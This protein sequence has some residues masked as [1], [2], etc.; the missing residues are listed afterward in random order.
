MNDAITMQILDS[1][2]CLIEILESLDFTKLFACILM[3]KQA[4]LVHVLHDHVQSM[5]IEDTVPQFDDVRVL[6]F[7]M[8]AVLVLDCLE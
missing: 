1:L 3:M 6:E 5:V 2:Q 7:A 8:K 4:A